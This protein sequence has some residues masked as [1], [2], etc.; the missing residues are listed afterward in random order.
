MNR[1]ANF[2]PFTIGSWLR[3]D[4]VAKGLTHAKPR[5]VLEIGAG[6]GALGVRLAAEAD[7]IGL[8]PDVISFQL[9]RNRLHIIGR[10]Q[11][12]CGFSLDLVPPGRFDMVCALEVLEHIEDDIAALRSWKARINE[13]GYLLLSVPAG[14]HRFG[15]LD[16]LVGH[17]RRYDRADLIDR[18]ERANFE[19][20]QW[21]TVGAVLGHGLHLLGNIISRF[22]SQGF[23]NPITAS[24]ASGRLLRPE[25]WFDGAARWLIAYPFRWLQA[26]FVNSDFGTGYVVLARVPGLSCQGS[27]SGGYCEK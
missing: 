8:E 19:I 10:G 7:Y 13:G 4:A 6:Q 23:V 20:V 14:S 21:S 15:R 17:C 9:L 25:H 3:A 24:M 12:I 5:R 22:R 2:P 11:A 27:F 18:L 1:L 16:R 26:P